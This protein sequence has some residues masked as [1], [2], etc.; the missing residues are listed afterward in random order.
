MASAT[1]LPHY[2]SS[3]TYYLPEISGDNI[4]GRVVRKIKCHGIGIYRK[5]E[6]AGVSSSNFRFQREM[7]PVQRR[8]LLDGRKYGSFVKTWRRIEY[9]YIAQISVGQLA[10]FQ[11][12]G[13]Y[14]LLKSKRPGRLVSYFAQLSKSILLI[15]GCGQDGYMTTFEAPQD[16]KIPHQCS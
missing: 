4:Q 15:R 8:D 10:T 5:N 13:E 6:L 12:R 7:R 14:Q 16:C 11:C 2:P 9:V 3:F 1:L